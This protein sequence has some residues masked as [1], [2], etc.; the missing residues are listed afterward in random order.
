MTVKSFEQYFQSLVLICISFITASVVFFAIALSISSNPH[1]A[2]ASPQQVLMLNIV[3]PVFAVIC[4]L[5]GWVIY[6]KRLA[7]VKQ[8]PTLDEKL[9]G[10]KMTVIA[11][12]ILMD[13]PS[14]IACLCCLLAGEVQLLIVTG[15]MILIMLYLLPQKQRL[16]K[17]LNFSAAQIEAINT[18]KRKT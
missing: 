6:K 13:A 9:A 16:M 18:G 17:E 2:T 8:R 4:L 15:I 5:T 3:S 11:R 12:Y 1:G 10:Y 14:L 7:K